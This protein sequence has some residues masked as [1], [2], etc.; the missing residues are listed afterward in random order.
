MDKNRVTEKTEKEFEQND[1][2]SLG[3]TVSSCGKQQTVLNCGRLTRILLCQRLE[4]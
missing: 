1:Y 3:R 2:S 4:G